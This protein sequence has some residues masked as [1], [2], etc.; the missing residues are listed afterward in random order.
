VSGAVVVTPHHC[1]PDF[2]HVSRDG[3]SLGSVAMG[4]GG[5]HALALDSRV[6]YAPTLDACVAW[7]SERAS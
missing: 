5:L 7:L 6:H 1:L 3:R 2:W 4:A